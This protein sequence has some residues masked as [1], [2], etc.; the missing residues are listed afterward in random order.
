MRFAIVT[1]LL[2]ILSGCASI[3][4]GENQSLSVETNPCRGATCKLTNDKGTWYVNGTPGSV[5]VHRAYGDLNLICEEGAFKSNPMVVASTTKGMAFGNIIFGG[6]IGAGV[7]AS[8]GAAYDYPTV[9]TVPMICSGDPQTV[10]QPT[11]PAPN[12]AQA[13]AQAQPSSK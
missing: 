11:P 9:I 3:T 13:T 8:T 10:V 7:D 1:V 12:R 6:L 5:T 2:V 4:T